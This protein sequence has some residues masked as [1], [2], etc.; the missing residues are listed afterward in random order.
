MD[1]WPTEC[2]VKDVRCFDGVERGLLRPI[3]LLVGENSTG[4]SAFLGCY[5]ILHRLLSSPLS[6]PLDPDFNEEPFP[7]GSFREIARARRGPGGRADEFRIGVGFQPDDSPTASVSVGF[8]QQGAQPTIAAMRYERGDSHV[9]VR[10]LGAKRTLLATPVGDHELEMPFGLALLLLS[11]PRVPEV[12]ALDAPRLRDYISELMDNWPGPERRMEASTSLI[13]VAP[14]RA[15]PR[16][17]YDPGRETASPEGL[18]VP[19]RLMRLHRTDKDNWGRL[20]DGLV[21]F[22]GE[23]GMFADIRVKAHGRQLSDP[24][25]LQVKARSASHAN[26]MDVGYGVSQSLPILVDILSERQHAFMLQQPEVH[27]H[28]RGQAELASFFVQSVHDNSNRFLIETHSDYIVDRVRIHVR[29]GDISA[30]DVAILYFEPNG[31]AVSIRNITLDEYGNL[32]DAPAGYREF[33]A[34]ETDRVL[35]FEE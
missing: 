8:Q 2:F 16:R 27:L 31:N 28:P 7:M 24:F 4:K 6:V 23:S 32:Q 17:T 10:S 22:G 1:R 25:Q 29:R 12:I 26:I 20:H 3:T 33:F 5:A 15:K 11:T 9:E 18:H 14:L 34:K 35:G 30:Q 21:A 13:A 19:M